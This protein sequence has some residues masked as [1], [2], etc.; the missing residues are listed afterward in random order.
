MGEVYRARDTRLNRAVAIK[1]LPPAFAE[2]ADRLRRFEQEAQAAG[3]LNH[4][5]IVAIYDLGRHEGAVYVVS[6]LLEGETL[7]AKL[8]GGALPIR[9]AVEY[10][11]QCARGLA[12]AHAKGITHRDI[13]PENLFVTSEGFVKILDFGLAKMAAPSAGDKTSAP[14]AALET[15]PGVVMPES[16]ATCPA[17]HLQRRGLAEWHLTA[18]VAAATGAR[19]PLKPWPTIHCNSVRTPPSA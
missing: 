11:A 14:T 10:A 16:L 1:I 3:S 6:E 2:D 12:A 15:D 9:K 18:G 17:A 8:A 4:P 13:K 5:N 7:R 19:A